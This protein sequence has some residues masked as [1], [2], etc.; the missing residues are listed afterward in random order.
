MTL[1]ETSIQLK[2]LVKHLL[3]MKKPKT[4]NEK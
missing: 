2:Q 1:K 4:Q 3:K